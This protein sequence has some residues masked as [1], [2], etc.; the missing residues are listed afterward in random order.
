[1]K[2]ENHLNLYRILKTIFLS[3]DQKLFGELD[4][5]L[6]FLAEIFGE[7]SFW[8]W[9]YTKNDKVFRCVWKH[10]SRTGEE[11]FVDGVGKESLLF[12]TPKEHEAG[13]N[14]TNRSIQI[15]EDEGHT[16]LL[17]SLVNE[18]DAIGILEIVQQKNRSMDPLTQDAF[19]EELSEIFAGILRRTHSHER[20][21]PDSNSVIPIADDKRADEFLD[22]LPVMVWET[23][24]DNAIVYANKYTFDIFGYRPEE[25]IGKAKT[26]LLDDVET[27]RIHKFIDP[28]IKDRKKYHITGMRA[29]GKDGKVTLIESNAVPIFDSENRWSG[30]RGVDRI[31]ELSLSA[32]TENEGLNAY[33]ERRVAE[34]TQAFQRVIE[35]YKTVQM[36]LEM[37]LWAANQGVWDWDLVK[38]K[39]FY[40][41]NWFNLLGYKRREFPNLEKAWRQLIHPDDIP[42]A[43]KAMEDHY[44]GAKPYYEVEY[45]MKKKTGEYAWILDKGRIVSYGKDLTPLRM[46]GIHSDITPRRAFEE[47]LKRAKEAAENA[48]RS[49]SEFLSNVNHELR[50]PLTIIMGLAETL[51][52]E[53]PVEKKDFPKKILRNSQQLLRLINDVIDLS[54]IEAGKFSLEKK[55]F[56]L[57]EVIDFIH[58][59]FSHEIE[60]KGL[61]F[62][63]G[64]L[65][66]ELI[67]D[68]L[69]LK[70]VL[71]N[72]VA[73][74]MKFTKSG[75]IKLSCNLVAESVNEETIEFCI[76]DTGIGIPETALN[77]IFER[78]YQIDSSNHRRYSGTGLGLSIVKE[79][80]DMMNGTIW[81]KSVIGTGTVFFLRIPFEKPCEVLNDQTV[82]P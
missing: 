51:L 25:L 36:R 7:A 10:L 74:A 6:P 62:I 13:E 61:S 67:G 44:S 81:V 53:L 14:E 52:M 47:E 15:P 75:C 12:V 68:S 45:R 82:Y 18:Q 73:N 55:P 46:V 66:K 33:L 4:R 77:K 79:L 16:R 50:T 63:V 48:N 60:K 39:I 29:K 27:D 31:V 69:R 59:S 3:T 21:M 17:L 41:E 70:Q 5:I 11:S 71:T 38:D 65:S 32:S 76:E 2:T 20:S 78:F 8:L 57:S 43:L 24:K 28:I 56:Q 37:V 80:V 35:R 72:L 30:Y 1:M 42:Y 58:Q 34:R 64:N 19:Y 9:D 22:S 54:K 49:K 40:N 23:D 26:E